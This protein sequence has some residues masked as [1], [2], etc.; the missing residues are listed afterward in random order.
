MG[1]R[2]RQLPIFALNTVLLPGAPLPLHVF[3]QRYRQMTADLMDGDERE[4]V[5]L[6]IKEGDEVLER[7]PIEPGRQHDVADAGRRSVPSG[8]P[9]APQTCEIGTTAYVE[10]VQPLADGRYF[11][12]CEGRE[13]V[14]LLSRTQETPYP[15]GEFEVLGDPG[16]EDAATEAIADQV[17]RAVRN[18]FNAVMPLIPAERAKQRA[19]L[20]RI[21]EAIPDDAAKLSYFVAR[22]LFTA[23][24]E[25]K[26]RLLEAPDVRSRLQR[27][28]PLVALEERL[29]R[30]GGLTQQAPGTH[31]VSL[32]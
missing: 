30:S 22:A 29:V 19:E 24:T 28:F 15:M 17:R 5:V 20:Q 12:V 31:N 2:T 26:Q 13:R 3:E 23:S 18:V 8:A 9:R 21:V 10:Q 6:L 11:L 4:F 7:P 16:A 27:A 32:N 1:A 25:D 14:R